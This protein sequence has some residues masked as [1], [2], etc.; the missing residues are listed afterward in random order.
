MPVIRDEVI[1]REI[2]SDQSRPQ[3]TGRQ[4]GTSL[5][6]TPGPIQLSN[7]LLNLPQ[8][9]LPTLSPTITISEPPAS[10]EGESSRPA[11]TGP[12]ENLPG[13]GLLELP[14][15]NPLLD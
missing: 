8:L 1:L 7:P 13:D 4:A 10:T 12:V 3:Q 9:D 6:L 11:D 14:S 2:I 15:H 5:N